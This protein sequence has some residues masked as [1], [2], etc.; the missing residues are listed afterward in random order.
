[1]HSVSLRATGLAAIAL[2]SNLTSSHGSP[3]Q[4]VESAVQA[5]AQSPGLTLLAASSWY[6]T[7]AV[8][9]PQPD[10]INGCVLVQT[11][12]P[13]PQRA[14][15]LLHQLLAIEQQFGRR[16]TQRWGPRTLDLDLLLYDGAVVQ[17]PILTL[18]HPH[19]AERAFVLVPLA[20]ILPDWIDP[21]SGLSILKLRNRLDC[22][23]VMN[24][25][26]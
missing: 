9:P 15:A 21:N 3:I 14:E 2:G 1:M 5:L 7:T 10:Y 4:T 22:S 11:D 26:E 23:G 6:Q 8:G 19:L 24:L 17:T 18:P 25:S 13:T 12:P 20:E 16:R